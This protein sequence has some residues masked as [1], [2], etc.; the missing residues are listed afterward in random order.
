MT[1]FGVTGL[2]IPTGFRQYQA[3]IV[4]E[5]LSRFVSELVY[6]HDGYFPLALKKPSKQ[7]PWLPRGIKISCNRFTLTISEAQ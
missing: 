3:E 4:N 7:N 6:H 5:T 1:R 2:S